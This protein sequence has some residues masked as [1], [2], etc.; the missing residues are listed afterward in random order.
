MDPVEVLVHARV[1][2]SDSWCC[3]GQKYAAA[4]RTEDRKTVPETAKIVARDI[5]KYIHDHLG[6]H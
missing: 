2:R 3:R 4:L 6:A 1:Y 5:A